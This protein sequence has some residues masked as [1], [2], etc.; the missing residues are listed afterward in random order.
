MSEA[1]FDWSP[2]GSS[3]WDEARAT[4]GATE[5]QARFAC[6]YHR[7]M[8]ASG[9][10]KTAGYAG[11][12]DTIRQAGSRAAKSTAVMNLLALAKAEGNGD[13]PD[14]VV[15]AAEAKRILSR[16]ARGS[17]PNVKVK[18]IE[19]LAKI[20]AQ[21]RAEMAERAKDDDPRSTLR[22]IERY[23]P[24][25]AAYLAHAQGIEDWHDKPRVVSGSA[26]EEATDAA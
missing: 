5:L 12:D 9:S 1:E 21:E 7:G 26:A 24:E 17:D 6:C 8:T 11:D 25:L 19:S 13:G 10:A 18:A 16:L 20:A 3:F 2:L 15:D 22:E 23:S 14:G 4:T